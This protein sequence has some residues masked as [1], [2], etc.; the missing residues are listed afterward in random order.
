MADCFD[1]IVGLSNRD[2]EC[3]S[4]GRPVNYNESVSGIFLTDLLPEEEIAAL[5]KCDATLWDLLALARSTAIKDFRAALNATMQQRY[6]IK[7]PTYKGFIGEDKGASSLVT[8]KTSAGIRI[9]TAGIRS[10]YLKITRIMAMF[11]ATGTIDLTVYRGRIIDANT[12]QMELEQVGAVIP[13]TTT[14]N[15]RAITTEGIT[16]PLLGDFSQ[17]QDY[18][19]TYDYNPANKPKLNE[20]VCGCKSK[21]FSQTRNVDTFTDIYK[22]LNYSGQFA[23]HNLVTLGG[24]EGDIAAGETIAPPEVGQYM[25]GLSF[26]MEIGCDTAAGLCGMVETFGANP[27]SMSA[28][29]AIQRR[30]CS[31]LMRRRLASSQPNRANSVNRD[32]VEKEM[33]TWE[34]EYAEIINYLSNNMPETSNDC[35]ECKPKVRMGAILG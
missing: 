26:E 30:A 12:G 11:Q 15:G 9:R 31:F 28:A 4:V 2:C 20:V 19:L 13:F 10:G 3:N 21:S 23:W 29:T 18:L 14:A 35:L 34:A 32:G 8:T 5:A 17:Q 6:S 1:T 16:L 7:Y 33:R 22:G 24:W 25:N 27:Y